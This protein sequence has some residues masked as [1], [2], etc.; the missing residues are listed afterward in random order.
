[1][2]EKTKR[3]WLNENKSRY[4]KGDERL[5]HDIAFVNQYIAPDSVVL[6]LCCG[7]GHMAKEMSVKARLVYAVD[8]NGQ[9]LEQMSGLANVVTVKS[10]AT[11]FFCDQKFDLVTIFGAIQYNMGDDVRRIYTNCYGMLKT[12][13]CLLVSG[14]WGIEDTVLVDRFSEELQ[15]QYYAEY[16]TLDSECSLLEEIGFQ[17]ELHKILPDSFDR[18]DNTKFMC[19]AAH[20]ET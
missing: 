20:K 17:T 5:K 10:D 19:I 6:D 2:N 9:F 4:H 18:F 11:E 16:R 12:G 7:E 15:K 8:I 13:A 3:Y 1:M 14:Q